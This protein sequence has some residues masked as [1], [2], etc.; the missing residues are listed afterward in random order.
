[1]I[2]YRARWV[3]PIVS[4]P[5]RDGVVAVDGD[6]IAF[7]G[8]PEEAPPGDDHD[9][10]EVLLLPG[11]VNAHTHLELTAMRG[12]LEDLDFRRWILRLTAARRD[13]LDA[14]A[15]L[16]SA[17]YGIEEG[18][19]AGITT[20]ADTSE[21]GVVVRAMREAGVRGV[22]YQE[23][24]GPDP[25]QC[26]ASITALRERVSGLRYLETPLVRVGVSPHAPYTVSDPLLR[27]TTDFARQHGLSMAIH[28]AEST[29]EH[30]LIVNGEGPFADGLRG[31]GI[32][33]GVRG[34]SPID[35]LDRLGV[36]DAR[37][38]LIHC[39]RAD[40]GDIAAIARS[41][42]A[43][44]HCPISNAKLGHGMAP[45]VEFLGAGITVG[46]GSDSVASNNHM[47]LL[48]EAR[49][50]LLAQRARLGSFETP[51]AADVLELATLGG[52]AALGLADVVGSLEEGKQAD[53]AA[54]PL[55]RVAPTTDPTTAAVL[56]LGGAPA[57]FV[58]VA[59]KTLVSGSR[60]TN[61]RPELAARMQEL[62]DALADWLDAGGETGR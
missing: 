51:A 7:V 28:I 52:A 27:A 25:A 24:F 40:E 12:F 62:G 56:S 58:A 61:R 39:V 34:R 6:R 50:A 1:V 32:H 53:L 33:V 37:P 48:D 4:E 3:V 35:L 11:L 2:N 41:K 17:R 47:D 29:E 21:S 44:A 49:V 42:C 46:L 15:L 14:D 59:G 22:V 30:R 60:L 43:V 57:S 23:V 9:L 16:D 8:P 10:G 36:L 26:E 5:L 54:F 38:L 19:R 20:Y 55:D 45:L 31:R 13:V 18:L